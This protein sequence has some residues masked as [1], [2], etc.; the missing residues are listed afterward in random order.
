MQHMNR[1]EL[2]QT[3]MGNKTIHLFKSSITTYDSNITIKNTSMYSVV[4]Y[5]N[6][7]R[8]DSLST[9]GIGNKAEALKIYNNMLG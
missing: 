8:L 1:I 2:K 5:Q 7:E 3:V 9:F 6:Y 4:V